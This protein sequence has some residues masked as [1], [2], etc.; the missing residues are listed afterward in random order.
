MSFELVYP[1]DG[2]L[3][4]GS[5]VLRPQFKTPPSVTTDFPVSFVRFVRPGTYD[6]VL[7]AIY[8]KLWD[9]V[10]DDVLQELKQWT[11]DWTGIAIDV[12]PAS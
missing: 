12:D 7:S 6:Q 1:D 2:V 11:G 9:Q 3:A 10:S 4:G 8:G 5:R